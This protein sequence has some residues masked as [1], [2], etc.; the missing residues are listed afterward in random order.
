MLAVQRDGHPAGCTGETR[1]GIVI[2]R[3]ADAHYEDSAC[4]AIATLSSI[5]LQGNRAGRPPPL[6][7]PSRPE[8]GPNAP[9]NSPSV[10]HAKGP[11]GTCAPNKRTGKRQPQC[12][13]DADCE[14]A[15]RCGPPIHSPSAMSYSVA[16]FS[17]FSA[18]LESTA[19]HRVSP[20]Y[21]V[22]ELCQRHR[23]PKRAISLAL[24]CASRSVSFS[25]PGVKF[26]IETAE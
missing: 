19:V 10:D 22:H 9:L 13:V 6:L 24:R 7:A 16:P 5:A 8:R 15:L 21:I 11:I 18:M 4:V 3:N 20:R 12:L 23:R 1:Y 17:R 26:W 2:R 14:D 25:P